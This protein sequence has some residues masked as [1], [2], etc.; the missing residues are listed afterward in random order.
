MY[1]V[2]ICLGNW[3]NSCRDRTHYFVIKESVCSC[4]F[5]NRRRLQENGALEK[6]YR[7]QEYDAENTTYKPKC[8]V[9]QSLSPRGSH[10]TL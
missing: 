7:L 8:H 3:L 5:R 2:N 1:T 4:K 10:V 9:A 6:K